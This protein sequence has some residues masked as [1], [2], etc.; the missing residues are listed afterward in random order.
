MSE[1]LLTLIKH[2][3]YALRERETG[4]NTNNQNAD[5]PINYAW[6]SFGNL[7][8]KIEYG[9]SCP[10]TCPVLKHGVV[11]SNLSLAL[12]K[13]KDV[14]NKLSSNICP[15]PFSLVKI[16]ITRTDEISIFLNILYLK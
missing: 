8:S 5:N 4:F 16:F 12:K 10:L 11:P 6:G 2:R 14:V 7:E 1:W 9:A 3:N 15:Y 13:S